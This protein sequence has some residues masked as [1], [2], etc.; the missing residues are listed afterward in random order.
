MIDYKIVDIYLYHPITQEFLYKDISDRNPL[1]SESPI[2]PSCATIIAP[3]EPQDGYAIVWIGNK[4]EF[5]EDHRNEV[6][7]NAKTKKLETIDFI[8]SLDSYYYTPDSLIANKPEGDYW[9]FDKELNEWIGDSGLYKLYVKD[10]FQEYWDIK[11]NT[12]FEFNGFRYIATWRDLYTS[13]WVTLKDGI[14]EQ[15]RL[16]DFDGKF[17]IVTLETM[18]PIIEKIAK[19]NDEMFVDKH[20]LETFFAKNDDFKKLESKFKEYIE[21]EYK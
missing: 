7:Y 14:M 3:P 21:K 11:Q 19:V 17:N 15:Y 20:N 10:I 9:I 13:I 5:K 16:Q 2:I 4:W 1:D 18:K 12:P 6:W 8:G